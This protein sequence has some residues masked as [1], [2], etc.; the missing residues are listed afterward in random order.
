MCW[1]SLLTLRAVHM[2]NICIDLLKPADQAKFVEFLEFL[3][4]LFPASPHLKTKLRAMTSSRSQ[5]LT[6]GLAQHRLWYDAVFIDRSPAGLDE[7]WSLAKWLQSQFQRLGFDGSSARARA[8][9]ARLAM[10]D[11]EGERLHSSLYF[12]FRAELEELS[13]LG[14]SKASLQPALEQRVK[15]CSQCA[16]ELCRQVSI[17]LSTHSLERG[18]LLAYLWQ[19]LTTI[20]IELNSENNRLHKEMAHSER[21][22]AQAASF[23]ERL[24]RQQQELETQKS[25]TESLRKRHVEELKEQKESSL[26]ELE[27]SHKYKA[28]IQ[29]LTSEVSQLQA[30]SSQSGESIEQLTSENQTLAEENRQLKE[31][32]SRLEQARRSQLQEAEEQNCKLEE[33]TD[34]M[35]MLSKE[36]GQLLKKLKQA[37]SALKAQQSA[38][39]G[40]APHPHIPSAPV[41]GTSAS[42]QVAPRLASAKVAKPSTAAF[43]APPIKPH[44]PSANPAEP[45]ASKMP[46]L[47]LSACLMDLKRQES[48]SAASSQANQQDECQRQ[49]CAEPSDDG[50]CS[51]EK[52]G[53][54]DEGAAMAEMEECNPVLRLH[55]HPLVVTDSTDVY[56]RF[57][58]AWFC[59][60]CQATFR[61]IKTAPLMHHCSIC[62]YD[63]C[64][65]CWEKVMRGE[66]IPCQQKQCQ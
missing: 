16:Y 58:G 33:A 64:N 2:E 42:H 27:N 51:I 32:L 31:K 15:A 46:V 3:D 28:E 25:L 60:S 59:D 17:S 6:A 44:P 13:Q 34:A 61:D 12:N 4:K 24:E 62:E 55:P 39:A 35:A 53:N 30:E 40:E 22:K 38:S 18:W 56:T 43:A 7:V 57:N 36:N 9:S 19:A 52:E 54:Q 37:E 20:V 10:G 66:T 41:R 26:H 49:R 48:N 47:D 21:Y 23:E 50:P 11:D 65:I 29:R 14:M 63:L 8:S 5:R 1:G 45:P